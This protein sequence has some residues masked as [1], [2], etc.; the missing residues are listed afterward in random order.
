M[1]IAYLN[2]LSELTP[3]MSDLVVLASKDIFALLR[4]GECDGRTKSFFCD[5]SNKIVSS[6]IFYLNDTRTVKSDEI[7]VDQFPLN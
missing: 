5:A 3:L 6:F 1:G 4:R 2:L 7:K